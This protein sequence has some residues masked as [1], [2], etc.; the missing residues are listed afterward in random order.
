[1][2]DWQSELD[3]GDNVFQLYDEHRRLSVLLQSSS[4]TV[5]VTSFGDESKFFNLKPLVDLG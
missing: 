5:C 1:M 3:N 2:Y 4:E